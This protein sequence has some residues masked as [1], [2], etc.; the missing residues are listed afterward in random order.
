MALTQSSLSLKIQDEIDNFFT[1]TEPDLASDFADA[2]A[3]AI[4]DEIQANAVIG[5]GS[6]SN[7]GGPITGAG[8][9][10]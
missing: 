4:V 1:I 10:T 6:F 5:P 2:V 8:T 3:K 9:I 7:S